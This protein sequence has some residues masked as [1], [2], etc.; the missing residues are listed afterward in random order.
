MPHLPS[1]R[2]LTM[3]EAISRQGT[4]RGAA[5]QLNTTPSAIS[6]RIADLEATLGAPLFNRTGRSVELNTAGLEYVRE[7]KIALGIIE[8]SGRRFAEGAKAIPVRIALHPPFAHNWLAPRLN[9]LAEAFPD[10][11]FEFIYAERPSETFADEVDIAIDWGTEKTCVSKG[12]ETL[13]PR[14]VTL[15]TSAD[16]ARTVVGAWTLE[17]LKERRLLQM[18]S[19]PHEFGQWL[20]QFGAEV[21]DFSASFS[22]ST[23]AL[24]L[25]AV[26][27]GL[28]V[29][30][31]C[32]NL[33]AKDL[34]SGRLIAP[35][36][37]V[38][39][40]GDCYYI[41]KMPR[42][43]DKRLAERISSWF[44]SESDPP[45]AGTEHL[46]ASI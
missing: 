30:L 16:Y 26:R 39:A 1:M 34:Q 9:R 2:S 36:E 40:T 22:F 29:G 17:T 13:V 21:A 4:F 43:R 24:L 3:L 32:R 44:V 6:H 5:E 46:G 37:Q 35:F 28:G 25:A 38:L 8:T 7:I 14:V 15:V 18:S 33:I 23:T 31:S 19:A 27:N 11:R 12:G 42:M 10:N 41:V 20:E 45:D